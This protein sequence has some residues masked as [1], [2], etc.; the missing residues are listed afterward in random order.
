MDDI[1][2]KIIPVAIED[3]MR[4]SYLNYAMSVIVSRA[5]PDVRDGLKP[6][7]RRILYSMHQMGLRSDRAYKK[8][9]RIVGDVLGKYHPHGDAAIYDSL[10]RLAQ[11]FSMRYP[12]VRPQGNFG[13]IDGDPPAA[14][15]YTE[16]KMHPIAEEML[17][18]IAKETIDFGANYDESL[19]E[20]LVLPA[21]FP[22]LLVNGG[23][24]I[25]V[26]MATNMAPHNLGEVSKAISAYIANPDIT[27]DELAS[28]VKGP[29]FPG[30]GIIYG[31]QGIRQSFETGRGKITVRARCSIEID[32]R[33]TDVIIVT[34]L[35]YLVN[36]ATLITKIADL[37]R[38]K[39]IEG[40]SDL[41]DESDRNGM[42]VVIE[43]KRSAVPRVVLNQLFTNT[44]LQQNFNVNNLALVN[45]K[46][47]LL[48]LKEMIFHFVNHRK[49][50]IT[51]RTKYELRKAEERA[52]LLEG[53]K[54][55][56]QNIDEVV[57]IIKKSK[58]VIT[59]KNHLMARFTLSEVQAQAILDMRLQ[60]LT[61][62]ETQKIVD[63]L[64]ELQGKIA[65]FKDLLSSEQKILDVVNEELRVTTDKFSDPRRTEI[66]RDEV[67]EF[68]VEDLITEEDMV[69][70][71]SNRGFVKRVPVSAYRRQGRG[72]RGSSSA[73][74]RDEDFIN[75]LF[76]ASTHDHIMFVTSIGKAYWLKVHEI[77][78]GSRQS[79]GSH[80]KALMNI[81]PDEEINAVVS[82]K[83]FTDEEFLFMVTSKGV[84]KK[85]AVSQFVNAKKRGI[86]AIK[87]DEGDKL[88][89]A[90]LTGGGNEALL[91][92]RKGL[93]LKFPEDSV[94]AMGRATRGVRGMKL[95]PDD[96]IASIL[97]VDSERKIL[98]VTEDG[99]GKRLDFDSFSVHARATQGQICY[100][101]QEKTGRIVGAL[102]V[103]EEDNL[104]SITSMGT[105]L[106]IEVS[107]I[108]VQGRSSSGVI[109]SNISEADRVV[110]IARVENEENE[111]E[112]DKKIEEND[113]KERVKEIESL[114][115]EEEIEDTDEEDELL[116]NEEEDDDEDDIQD[117]D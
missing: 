34:E 82:I 1:K 96:E 73:K 25:A 10:V 101:L 52:H 100:K 40:I 20:P 44:S 27:L 98:L 31:T 51:R 11:D 87:L 81:M 105:T 71:I 14:M 7:H 102:S 103:K 92:S 28:Y 24:G 16:A 61:S 85:A 68:Q 84:V 59:A 38:N 95:R 39:R 26:G 93:A 55:A 113:N 112:L 36:K 89:R 99:Y 13:S 108:P 5:L 75:H 56:L 33:G 106:R 23:S 80:I 69:V 22:Y 15:R 12:V 42:R 54:I 63:E 115:G 90:Q 60:K 109:I 78:E 107:Q 70:L 21:A 3:E 50:V 35:P 58:D 9:G 18:D 64:E 6:V 97:M 67:E 104:M 57:E 30:G 41:R 72:G 47:K 88:V 37:V 32:S 83:E 110:A 17:R 29:D 4:E 77:P 74:L 86:I 19:K 65:Y 45:G 91:V 116:D 53:L 48:S 117:D 49:D 114:E 94:R 111:E 62:L 43:L 79:K 76:V 8:C 46:P 66:L 2:K